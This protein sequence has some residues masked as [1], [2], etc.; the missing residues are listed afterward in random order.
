VTG[1]VPR[2]LIYFKLGGREISLTI[3]YVAL[4]I[5]T[6]VFM[7]A[8][9][10]AAMIPIFGVIAATAAGGKGAEPGGMAVALLFVFLIPAI[11]AGLAAPLAK[12]GLAIPVASVE[13]G[14]GLGEAWEMSSGNFW[15]LF[16]GMILAFLVM[17]ALMLVATFVAVIIVIPVGMVGASMNAASGLWLTVAVGVAI[18]IIFTLVI[19]SISLAIFT[20]LFSVAYKELKGT[21]S[22]TA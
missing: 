1:D 20:A 10:I 21:E 9:I 15:P 17:L 7:V 8:V 3:T 14:L 6:Y 18:Y 11:I 16:W 5:I 12:F 13:G 4:G 22:A 2:G 19:Y